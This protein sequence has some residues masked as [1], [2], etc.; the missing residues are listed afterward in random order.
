[1]SEDYAD[2]FRVMWEEDLFS[3]EFVEN[4]KIY[5]LRGEDS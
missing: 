5:F 3:E 2:T 4:C 1:V